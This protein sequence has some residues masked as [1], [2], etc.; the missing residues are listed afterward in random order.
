LNTLT[1]WNIRPWHSFH[2]TL[3]FEIVV[4][5][6][7]PDN[8]ENGKRKN[9]HFISSQSTGP[10]PAMFESKEKINSAIWIEH[11]AC[12]FPAFFLLL[13]DLKL[14]IDNNYCIQ[15]TE[16]PFVACSR[17]L[18]GW[19]QHRFYWKF[20]VNRLKRDPKIELIVPFSTHIFS[21]WSIPLTICLSIPSVAI[22]TVWFCFGIWITR[23]KHR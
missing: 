4:L 9:R 12:Q 1:F 6:L 22:G 5:S 20:S 18:T 23:Q 17:P 13:L 14:L 10:I 8:R 3:F 16:T 2:T 7:L 15:I 19:V 21:H 11:V